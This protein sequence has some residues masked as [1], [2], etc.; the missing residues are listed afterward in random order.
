MLAHKKCGKDREELDKF[1]ELYVTAKLEADKM[2][3]HISNVEEN[4]MKWRNFYK[5]SKTK[6]MTWLRKTESWRNKWWSLSKRGRAAGKQ[7]WR[8]RS[9]IKIIKSGSIITLF[10]SSRRASASSK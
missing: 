10:T 2:R 5:S 8:K 4:K 9:W 6:T 1:K 7:K 3:S